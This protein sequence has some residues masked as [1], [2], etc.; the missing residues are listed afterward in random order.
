MTDPTPDFDPTPDY[1]PT[2]ATASLP[3]PST[4]VELIDTALADADLSGP[5]AEHPAQL[6]SAVELLQQVLRNPPEQ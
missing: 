3:P 1:D 2:V 5:A 4:G 6:A